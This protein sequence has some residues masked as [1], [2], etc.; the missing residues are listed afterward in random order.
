MWRSTRHATWKEQL[1]EIGTER[2]KLKARIADLDR[3]RQWAE[4]LPDLRKQADAL[5]MAV[6][7][8]ANDGDEVAQRLTKGAERLRMLTEE[9]R[10]LL[11]TEVGRLIE[12]ITTADAAVAEAR[13]RSASLNAELAARQTDAE[14]LR[15]E[16]EEQFPVLQA[17]QEADQEL[18]DGLGAASFDGRGI[19]TP[20]SPHRTGRHPDQACGPGRPATTAAQGT[21]RGIPEGSRGP[22]LA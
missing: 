15:T 10:A 16:Y 22:E 5:E 12:S 2:D 20:A 17:H 18:A 19:R 8:T 9:Q 21:C 3:R 13:A 11:G 14:T 4:E 6:V 7:G 1:R